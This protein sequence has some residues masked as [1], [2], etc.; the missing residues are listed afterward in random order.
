MIF[1]ILSLGLGV[2]LVP[3]SHIPF[4]ISKQRQVGELDDL[5]SARREKSGGL[6][7]I[8]LL[9]V[10]SMGKSCSELPID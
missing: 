9:L 6:M 8:S 1:T 4:S 5:S 7:E 2:I 3:T 10:Q